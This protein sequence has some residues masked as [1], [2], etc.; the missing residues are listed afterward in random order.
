[1]TPG[2]PAKS[3]AFNCGV[4]TTLAVDRPVSQSMD[5]FGDQHGSG[6][7]LISAGA[8]TGPSG[9]ASTGASQSKRREAA[10]MPMPAR[11]A[12]LRACRHLYVHTS[13]MRSHR[14]DVTRLRA[15][16]SAACRLRAGYATLPRNDARPCPWRPRG[17]STF[18]ARCSVG[19][20][21]EKRCKRQ[22]EAGASD[23]RQC[24]GA[25]GGEIRRPN[26]WGVVIACLHCLG[27]WS[28]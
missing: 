24:F 7:A 6:G 20:D 3:R 17:G 22:A 2:S 1:M 26:P 8:S 4:E 27:G 12:G 13:S 16:E 15:G 21:G 10:Q 14:W 28:R 23:A 5:K 9:R 25:L 18:P 11:L 19:V